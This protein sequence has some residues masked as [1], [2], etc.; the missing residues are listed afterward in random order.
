[1][2]SIFLALVLVLCTV[3]EGQVTVSNVWFKVAQD[4]DAINIPIGTVAR[5][6]APAGTVRTYPDNTVTL[7]TDQWSTTIF[8][9]TATTVTL[10]GSGMA[11][12]NIS[13]PALG[14][15]KEFD[16]LETSTAQTVVVNGKSLTV[17]ALTSTPVVTPP[18]VITPTQMANA[19][20]ICTACK[21]TEVLMST[22][23]TLQVGTDTPTLF[24]KLPLAITGDIYGQQNSRAFQVNYT[25]ST[26]P[27]TVTIPALAQ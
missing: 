10:D 24:S 15:V 21:L 16:V 1:M 2:K 13:D 22:P 8:V 14:Y 26:G 20:K 7:Q 17:P 3:V 4:G 18:V 23:L 6:G 19:F 25:D 27:H 12:F 5:W 11:L 9:A